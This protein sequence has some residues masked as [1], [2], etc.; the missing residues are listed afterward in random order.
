M[1]VPEWPDPLNLTIF[2]MRSRVLKATRIDHA[3]S[4]SNCNLPLP[5]GGS[6]SGLQIHEN[7]SKPSRERKGTAFAAPN[8][9]S[10]PQSTAQSAVCLGPSP[11]Q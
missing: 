4:D 8:P 1:Q 6:S 5:N 11:R 9:R 7:N 10:S 2:E 3:R